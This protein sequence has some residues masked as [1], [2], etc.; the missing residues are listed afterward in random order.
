LIAQKQEVTQA[1]ATVISA[2]SLYD[3]EVNLRRQVF[4]QLPRLVSSIMRTLEA[5]GAS[6]EKLDD[7]RMF[8]RQ[9]VGSI[10]KNWPPVPSADAPVEPGTRSIL[11]LAYASKADWFAKLVRAIVAE[12][13]YQANEP[14]LSVV[15]LIEKVSQL[16]ALNQQVSAARVAWSNSRIGRNDLFYG[17]TQSMCN[18][19]RA[20]K[21][22]VRAIYGHNS[23]QYAQVKVLSF[24]KPRV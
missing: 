21:K 20:V 24:N 17:Q 16:N 4:N 5:S 7:A 15:G 13:L 18:T 12:P 9:L 14:H 10:N 23:E 19:G 3:N 6:P 11:Q 2:K 1:L 22:Y 8:A